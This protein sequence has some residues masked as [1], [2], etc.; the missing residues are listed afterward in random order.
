M[1]LVRRRVTA[2]GGD[3]SAQ[4][5]WTEPT[6]GGHPGPPSYYVM[7][8]PTGTTTWIAGPGPLSARTTTIPGL[9]NG[10]TYDV[11]VFATSTDG[12][13]S[14]LATTTVTPVRQYVPVTPFRIFDTRNG[15]GGVGTA[16]VTPNTLTY[17]DYGNTTLPLNAPAYV[18]NVTAVGPT[19]R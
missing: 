14:T 7:Y 8:R 5:F 16:P 4:V 15:Q 13:A 6:L 2:T 9:I 18:L 11:G 12:T 3:S 17:F 19:Q 1:T 10:T